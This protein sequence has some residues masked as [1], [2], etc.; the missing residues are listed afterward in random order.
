MFL[1]GGFV[2]S[3]VIAKLAHSKVEVE[4]LL[5]KWSRWRAGK[6]IRKVSEQANQQEANG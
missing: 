4:M 2:V 5:L 6:N 1:L 3:I